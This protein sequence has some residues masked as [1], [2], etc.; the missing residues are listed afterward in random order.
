M[1]SECMV[2]LQVWLV[3]GFRSAQVF[4]PLGNDNFKPS[5]WGIGW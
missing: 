4:H 3:F 1:Y 5:S 2:M